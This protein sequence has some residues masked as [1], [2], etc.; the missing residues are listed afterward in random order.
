MTIFRYRS[1]LQGKSSDGL[2][3]GSLAGRLYMS[4]IKIKTTIRYLIP[5]VK[6]SQFLATFVQN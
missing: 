4:K 2:S 1:A 3:G 5:I 6:K